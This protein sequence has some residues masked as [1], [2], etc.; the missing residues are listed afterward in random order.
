MLTNQRYS[1]RRSCGI[2]SLCAIIELSKLNFLKFRH[3]L[4]DEPLEIYIKQT[5]KPD[6]DRRP[7]VLSEVGHI[8]SRRWEIG[9][10]FLKS[11]L[12]ILIPMI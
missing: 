5:N 1:D 12:F 3:W 7:A 4:T 10:H 6:F 8:L 11:E 9:S 2:D